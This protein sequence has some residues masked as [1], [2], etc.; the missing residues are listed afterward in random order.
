M[1]LMIKGGKCNWKLHDIPVIMCM[2]F[3]M[4][5]FWKGYRE[6]TPLIITDRSEIWRYIKY[7]P[8]SGEDILHSPAK[9]GEGV[10]TKLSVETQ[11]FFDVLL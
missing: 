9:E 2:L 5:V 8:W 7:G 10:D 11:R 3:I 4:L 1:N 6:T